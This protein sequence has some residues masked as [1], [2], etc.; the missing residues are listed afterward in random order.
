MW[1]NI[2]YKYRT[3]KEILDL[4]HKF[5][6]FSLIEI[7]VLLLVIVLISA[8]VLYILPSLSVYFNIAKK[9][10]ESENKKIALKQILIQKEIEEDIQK[11][12]ESE[13]LKI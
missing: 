2:E 9:A 13:N 5:N 12:M 11:E 6:N 3:L 8:L 7:I 10:K 4:I 1:I